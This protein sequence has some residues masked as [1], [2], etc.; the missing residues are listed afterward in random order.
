MNAHVFLY[1]IY[2]YEYVFLNGENR[3]LFTTLDVLK[4]IRSYYIK[5]C[6]ISFVYGTL[7]VFET[8]DVVFDRFC[9]RFHGCT[10]SFN[11]N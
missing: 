6:T 8:L 4:M 2:E 11:N 5:Y 3:K 7:V 1:H 10:M 9:F